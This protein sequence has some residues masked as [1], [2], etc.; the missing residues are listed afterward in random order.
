[1]PSEIR[2][3]CEDRGGHEKTI[4]KFSGISL[5]LA[6]RRD[7]SRRFGNEE[8]PQI[9]QEERNGK[10]LSLWEKPIWI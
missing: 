5:S 1:L 10:V 2:D 6:R 8:G 3:L 7:F 9:R 4:E